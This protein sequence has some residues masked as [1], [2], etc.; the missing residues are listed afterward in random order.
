MNAQLVELIRQVIVSDRPANEKKML[1]NELRKLMSPEENR[2]HFRYVLWT[3]A[4]MALSIPIAVLWGL[5]KSTDFQVP[6]GLL[7]LGSAAI[8]ALAAFLT[9]SPRK[10]EESTESASVPPA[11]VPPPLPTGNQP[12]IPV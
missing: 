1:L 10:K 7:S 11:E 9:P 12:D 5:A 4:L 8:G 6:D 2:W 3:L